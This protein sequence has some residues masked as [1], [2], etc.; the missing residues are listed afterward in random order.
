M[1]TSCLD[2][3]S[4]KHRIYKRFIKFISISNISAQFE[5]VT[6]SKRYERRQMPIPDI[7]NI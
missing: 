6:R 4:I 5:E 3:Y 2:I 1:D 7:G